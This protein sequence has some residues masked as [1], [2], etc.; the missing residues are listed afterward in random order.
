MPEVGPFKG[1]LFDPAVAGELDAL[2][3][4]PYDVI[5]AEEL[6]RF[7]ARSPFNITW[8]DL[9]EGPDDPKPKYTQAGRLFRRWR[10]EGVLAPVG[11]AV[12]P[13]EM[14]FPLEGEARILR[15]VI[16]EVRLEDWGGGILPHER[17]M[18]GPVEDRL[19]Q[20]RATGANLSP[21]YALAR[22]VQA[23][24][25]L[26]D[27]VTARNAD[28]EVVD[29]DGVSH[30]LWVEPDTGALTAA[31][32]DRD[33]LIADGHHRYQTSL[34]LQDELRRASGP[35]P[36]DAVMMFIV[37][38][39]AEDPPVLPYHRLVRVHPIPKL[40]GDPAHDLND[41]LVRLRDDG[42][43]FG[44]AVR[45]ET[46]VLYLVGSPG[47]DP[48]AVRAL[49]EQVLDPMPGVTDIAFVKDANAADRA[50]R[51]GEADLALFLPPA[52]ARDIQQAGEARERLPE[53]STYF[54]PKLR[55]GL[56]I[57]PF[58]QG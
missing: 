38:V 22:G 18:P 26:L 41:L 13:Y 30:R 23:Q 2:T 35:G 14:A 48:P 50:V 24:A 44:V 1:L 33:V 28:R 53:K 19:A 31:Y 27:R 17:T 52:K 39:A 32:E 51:A 36:W 29:E 9:G 40:D 47:G 56:V 58:A 15:G 43:R 45:T 42:M 57:R 21:I 3:A 12:Y 54:W 5:G 34:V 10:D 46:G 11:P 6:D 4:P 16:L 49:H 7:R 20:M 8:V 37:D 55:T 25:E